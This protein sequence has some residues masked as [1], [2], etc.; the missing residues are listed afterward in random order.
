MKGM[1]P[2]ELLGRLLSAETTPHSRTRPPAGRDRSCDHWT[3][4]VLLERAAYLRKMARAGEGSASD[5]IREFG[6]HSANLHVRVRNGP[7][8]MHED[9]ALVFVVLEGRATLVAGG[10]LE[11]PRKA[12][13]GEMTGAGIEGGSSHELRPGDVAHIA[14]G[15]PHQV[16]VA[17]EKAFSYLA[18][19]IREIEEQ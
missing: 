1:Q 5:T 17:G 9:F 3:G 4:P 18:L 11:K 12:G 8:E 2:E 14:A 19:K 15:T 13:P 6:G 7:A 10:V 16:L